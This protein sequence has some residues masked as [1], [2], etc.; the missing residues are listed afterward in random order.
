MAA[1][2]LAAFAA[3]NALS[4][5]Y[6]AVIAVGMAAPA[7]RRRLAWRACVLPVLAVLLIAQYALLIGP[8]PPWDGAPAGSACLRA[9]DQ[10]LLVGGGWGAHGKQGDGHDSE[11][12]S[13][14]ACVTPLTFMSTPFITQHERYI[15]GS[16]I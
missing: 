13:L 7:A 15:S 5:L 8:P 4:L 10:G 2:L 1:L 3:T 6:L 11:E 14:K 9:P 16:Y 12:S